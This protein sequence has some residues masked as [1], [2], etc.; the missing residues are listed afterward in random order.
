MP[1]RES[2]TPGVIYNKQGTKTIGPI[3]DF[4]ELV[5]TCMSEGEMRNHV[6]FL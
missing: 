1:L 4:L 6:E 5:F 2:N 3:L